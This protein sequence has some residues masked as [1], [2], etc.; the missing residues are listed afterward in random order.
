MPVVKVDTSSEGAFDHKAME[1]A[2]SGVYICSLKKL[3][4]TV[5]TSKAQNQMVVADLVIEADEN[6]NDTPH[7]GKGVFNYIS[8]SEKNFNP[9][10]HLA[11]CFGAMTIEEM[12]EAGGVELER[13]SSDHRGKVQLGIQPSSRTVGGKEWKLSLLQNGARKD[14]EKQ[15]R[16]RARKKAFSRR[17]HVHER[18]IHAS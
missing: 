6:G 14:E 2:P 5:E 11:L 4:L 3:P 12:K 15:G 18:H 7:K 1:P 10:S 8:L 17:H 13:F 16:Y 9:I